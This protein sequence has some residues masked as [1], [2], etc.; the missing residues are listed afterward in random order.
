MVIESITLDDVDNWAG[1][2]DAGLLAFYSGMPKTHLSLSFS[3]HLSGNVDGT[4]L[5]FGV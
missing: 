3:F 4:S 2:E 5:N 1:Q